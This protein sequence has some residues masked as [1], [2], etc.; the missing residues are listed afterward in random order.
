MPAVKYRLVAVRYDRTALCINKSAVGNNRALKPTTRIMAGLRDSKFKGF[1]QV[2]PDGQYTVDKVGVAAFNGNAYV[3]ITL[4]SGE[5]SYE[6]SLNALCLK[7]FPVPDDGDPIVASRLGAFNTELAEAV[8]KVVGNTDV[9]CGQVADGLAS[10]KGA[11]VSL[12]STSHTVL[13][14]EGGTVAKT[15]YSLNRVEG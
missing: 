8:G 11:K 4:K 7:V 5:N 6:L 15:F 14:Y 2:V 1:R 9:T 12:H 10:F 3:A 13:T